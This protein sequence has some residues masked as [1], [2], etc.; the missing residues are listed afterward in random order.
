[1]HAHRGAAVLAVDVDADAELAER[2]DEIGD[3]SLAHPRVAVDHDRAVGQR[4]GRGQEA[5]GGAGVAYV[6]LRGRA[7]E[8]AAASPHRPGVLAQGDAA[9]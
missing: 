5:R 8:A 7:R 2:L 4:R 1:M 6:E 9:A 3:R